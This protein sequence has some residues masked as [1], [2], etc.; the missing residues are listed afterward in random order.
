MLDALNWLASAA[1]DKSVESGG[2]GG[3]GNLLWMLG[4]MF[5]L[6]WVIILRPQQKE[7]RERQKQLDTVKK[8]DRVVTIGG[9]HG[10][11]S[12]VDSGHNIV[13]V[14]V[15]PKIAIKF[16]RSAIGSVEPKASEQAQGKTEMGKN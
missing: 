11:V 9:M 5:L 4:A 10:K 16:N 2:G 1:Q 8:G 13:T 12:D 6:F 15:A 3:P 14:E 7:R